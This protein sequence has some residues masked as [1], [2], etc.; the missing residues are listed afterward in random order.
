MRKMMLM[1]GVVLVAAVTGFGAQ[2]LVPQTPRLP[3]GQPLES[4]SFARVGVMG[5]VPD[6][7]YVRPIEGNLVHFGRQVHNPTRVPMKMRFFIRAINI[8]GCCGQEHIETIRT[9]TSEPFVV[10]SGSFLNDSVPFDLSQ[11]NDVNAFQIGIE[12]PTVVD[13]KSSWLAHAL[14]TYRL[15]R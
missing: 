6:D 4:C 12:E 9:I 8:T 5:V 10:A 1:V 3:L 14:D 13:G 7:L 15:P 11:L 2:Q